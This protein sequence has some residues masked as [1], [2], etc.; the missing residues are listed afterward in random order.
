MLCQYLYRFLLIKVGLKF[1]LSLSLFC[2][3]FN[4]IKCPLND[5]E[6]N[7]LV[8]VKFS[9]SPPLYESVFL[10]LHFLWVFLLLGAFIREECNCFFLND[11]SFVIFKMC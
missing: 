10:D 6:L 7:L 1:K 9:L 2:L 4:Q 5:I 3:I 8:F 11:V